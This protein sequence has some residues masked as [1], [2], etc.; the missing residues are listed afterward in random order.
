MMGKRKKG[1]RKEEG[2]EDGGRGGGREGKGVEDI[3]VR[4]QKESKMIENTRPCVQDA[5]I[6]QT[7][8][9]SFVVVCS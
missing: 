7:I 6:I 1:W 9:Q 2:R 5:A 3:H 8:M 4:R